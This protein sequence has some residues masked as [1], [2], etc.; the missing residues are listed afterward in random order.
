VASKTEAQDVKLRILGARTLD[1]IDGL[2]RARLEARGLPE[3]AL[4]RIE[5]A[6]ND[7]LSLA[8]AFSRWV[9]G[10]ELIRN[11]LKLEPEAYDTD[12]EALLRALGLSSK[13]IEEARVTVQGRRRPVSNPKSPLARILAR[14]DGVTPEARVRMAK[15]IAPFLTRRPSV[16]VASGQQGETARMTV[17]AS[18]RAAMAQG[19]GIRIEAGRPAVDGE[20]HQRIV[21]ARRR[22]RAPLGSEPSS[23]H[24]HSPPQ[25][26][27]SPPEPELVFAER[28]RLPDRRKG[29][30]QKATVGGHKVYLHTGEFD[31]GELG[32][33]FIDMHKEGAAF[34][35]LMNNFAIAIS[36]GLQYGVPLEE[37]VD[38][39]V[40]TRFEPAGEVTG[41]D[42][43]RR[44]TSILDYIFRE[45]A[46]S[47]LGRDDLAEV[48]NV[49]HDG[50]GAGASEGEEPTAPVRP[51]QLISRGFSRGVM[52]DNI[53]QFQS[54]KGSARLEQSDAPAITPQRSPEYL[55]DA[56]PS[57]GHFTLR[58][59]DGVAVCDACGATVQTA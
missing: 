3:D 51:E 6:L 35:S 27:P 46:V 52:P 16:T 25:H 57:C 54:R 18:V 58:P 12:G 21:E 24:F 9:V 14:A 28:R 5:A 11:R 7:G 1:Q 55:S 53:V 47:Y 2:E 59:D 39:F 15:A 45:L 41:N 38:A 10:D 26:H 56:C 4:D 19:L 44:A 48:E 33:I 17:H 23:T 30:I 22:A 13:E 20:I 36:I 42:S 31:D 34:R 49:S 29:Y 37:F 8:A 43:I 50:L 40:F 32:E